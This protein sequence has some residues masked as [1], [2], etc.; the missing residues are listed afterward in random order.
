MNRSQI[1]NT[2]D[3]PR[4]RRGKR[5]GQDRRGAAVV[6][7]AVV[8]NTLFLVIFTCVEFSRLNL[9]RNT[10]QNSAYYGARA[11]MVSGA[12]A[13]DAIDTAENLLD[14]I[15]AKG[16]TVTVNDG[17]PLTSTTE[18]IVVKVE[19]KYNK[20]AFF[21]PLFIPDHKCVATSN[22]KAERYDFFFDGG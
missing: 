22:V 7:F 5:R 6:E 16:V 10:A 3:R 20:N 21:A 12:T 2:T 9:I 15:G 18:K 13:Q 8:A 4:R 17:A 19:V 1:A 11:A 14:A